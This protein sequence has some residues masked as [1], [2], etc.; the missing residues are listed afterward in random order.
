[1]I[2]TG[3]SNTKKAARRPPKETTRLITEA[4]SEVNI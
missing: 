2:T 4:T 1:M 3:I